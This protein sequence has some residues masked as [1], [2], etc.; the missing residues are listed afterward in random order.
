MRSK[1][2]MGGLAVAIGFLLVTNPVIVNAA[3]QITSGD[4]KNNTIKS[5]D[6]KDKQIKA[7][8]LK[9]GAVDSAKLADNAVSSAKLQDGTVGAADLAA[10]A[11]SRLAVLASLGDLA[12]AAANVNMGDI[13]LTTGGVP[14]KNQSVL[15]EVS[16][17][18]DHDSAL[19][20][21][22]SASWLLRRDASATN[23]GSWSQE[24]YNG[25]P[26]EEHNIV[27]SFT[28][29]Q[30]SATTSTYHILGSNSCTQTL[31][32]DEDVVTAQAFPLA[33]NGASPTR[34]GPE[35][36]SHAGHDN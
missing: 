16:M 21:G 2:A 35:G 30:P 15:I 12:S 9:N 26:A 19:A 11:Q 23:L 10:G 31:F 1:L 5:K 29:T 20:S 34:P 22:C 3:G 32:T 27:F 24:L 13:A 6:I 7:A 4:I 18:L 17:Q 28:T 36:P 25:S 8:D 14:G 33:G